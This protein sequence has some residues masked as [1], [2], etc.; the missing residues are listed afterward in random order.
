MDYK[1]I[2]KNIESKKFEKIYF[3]HGE[4]THFIDVITNAIIEHALEDHERDFNQS[5]LYGKDSDARS[6]MAEAKGYPMMAQR[7]LVILKEAQNFRGI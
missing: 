4:E 1:L 7:R 5:I 3:L 6:I 2:I